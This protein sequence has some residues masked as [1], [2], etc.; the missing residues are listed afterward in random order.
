MHPKVLSKHWPKMWY[1]QAGDVKVKASFF[2]SGQNVVLIPGLGSSSQS[3][4]L[5]LPLNPLF[6]QTSNFQQEGYRPE[7][8]Y[9]PLLESLR[10][11]DVKASY[12]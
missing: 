11:V 3:E 10:K 6:M 5:L 7:E 12:C 9:G 4:V 8:V 1:L 2:P